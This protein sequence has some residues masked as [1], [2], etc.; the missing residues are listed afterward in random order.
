MAQTSFVSILQSMY[1]L[2]SAKS[3]PPPSIQACWQMMERFCQR[4][5]DLEVGSSGVKPAA[6]ATL[7]RD[8][9]DSVKDVIGVPG[10]NADIVADV[11]RELTAFSSPGDLP[12]PPPVSASFSNLIDST[13]IADPI[14]LKNLIGTV[15]SLKKQV[16]EKD[17]AEKQLRKELALAQKRSAATGSIDAAQ[18]EVQV[19]QKAL[20]ETNLREAVLV[21]QLT[22]AGLVP[23]AAATASAGDET[24][25]LQTTIGNMQENIDSLQQKLENM[26][27]S[28]VRELEEVA[29]RYEVEI[30]RYE[31]ELRQLRA[32]QAELKAKQQQE[33][34]LKEVQDRLEQLKNEHAQELAD[35]ALRYQTE[36]A[37][38][39]SESLGIVHRSACANAQ[40]DIV[41]FG[42][43]LMHVM[44][45]VGRN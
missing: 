16:A 33:E 36:I 28:H 3:K 26:D 44:H 23:E 15:E 43:V 21:K 20:T 17:A 1:L 40:Q 7:L 19:L 24:T 37:R 41:G 31:T 34:E 12:P 38:F 11:L 9:T 29:E 5:V 30:T 45:V 32:E 4:I 35:Q 27:E 14:Q 25:V 42:I 8:Y 6:F 39:E 2:V 22:N 18:M 10:S 13:N